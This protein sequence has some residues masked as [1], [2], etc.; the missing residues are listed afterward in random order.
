LSRI[1][2][3]EPSNT[4]PIGYSGT[5]VIAEKSAVFEEEFSVR[6]MLNFER[7]YRETPIF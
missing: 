7:G 2:E 4:A 5:S 1:Q 3:D 6:N